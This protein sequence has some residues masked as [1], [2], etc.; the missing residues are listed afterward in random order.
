M[1]RLDTAAV[2]SA[3]AAIYRE[4]KGCCVISSSSSSSS[5]STSLYLSPEHPTHI[6]AGLYNTLIFFFDDDQ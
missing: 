2:E 4:A 6:A 1:S 3:A 5:S